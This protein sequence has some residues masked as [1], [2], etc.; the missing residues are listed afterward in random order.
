[1]SAKSKKQ[2]IGLFCDKGKKSSFHMAHQRHQGQALEGCKY[3]SSKGIVLVRHGNNK[4]LMEINKGAAAT[5]K[6]KTTKKE[7]FF[8]MSLPHV[9]P[10]SELE[11]FYPLIR[12]LFPAR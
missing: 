7:D 5:D 8:N 3:S 10:T 1:M 12:K 2:T 4:V 11:D 6:V 9:I